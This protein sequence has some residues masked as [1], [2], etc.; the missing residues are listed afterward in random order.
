MSFGII[1]D[2]ADARANM[3]QRKERRRE[4][5]LRRQV[6]IRLHRESPKRKQAKQNGRKNATEV[7]NKRLHR[8]YK[9]QKK[10]EPDVSRTKQSSILARFLL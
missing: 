10:R 2:A 7:H 1:D 8:E 3:A 9:K 5:R 4:R 6:G